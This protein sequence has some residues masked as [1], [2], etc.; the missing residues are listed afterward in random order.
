MPRT[1]VD[2]VATEYRRLNDWIRGERKEQ[3]V[4]QGEMAEYLG[5]SQSQYSK[6]ENGEVDWSLKEWLKALEYL[7]VDFRGLL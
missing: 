1:N 4:N 6:R 7:K 2:Q 5:I 3:K